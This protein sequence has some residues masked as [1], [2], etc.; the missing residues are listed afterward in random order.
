MAPRGDETPRRRPLEHER[1]SC[2]P[3]PPRDLHTAHTTRSLSAKRAK[4]MHST[5][6]APA[7]CPAATTHGERASCPDSVLHTWIVSSAP[8]ASTYCPSGDTAASGCSLTSVTL[9]ADSTGWKTCKLCERKRRRTVDWSGLNVASS[10]QTI[11]RFRMGRAPCAHLCPLYASRTYTKPPPTA[12]DGQEQGA[13]RPTQ[14]CTARAAHLCPVE[15]KHL[16]SPL[17]HRAAASRPARTAATPA[18]GPAAPPL[19]TCRTAPGRSSCC[20]TA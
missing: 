15:D 7:A 20:R 3:P 9:S 4:R 19:R 14:T 6:T 11:R 8:P 13:A 12:V 17:T 18:A 16:S 5:Q 2:V 1:R 10:D